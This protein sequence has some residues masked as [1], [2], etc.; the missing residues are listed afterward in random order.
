MIVIAITKLISLKLKLLLILM[1]FQP[2]QM[3][4][5]NT[6]IMYFAQSNFLVNIF[7]LEIYIK[8]LLKYK[9]NYK[10]IITK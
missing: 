7:I 10:I 4:N 9:F 6:M 2:D 5:M 1:R 8:Y 3:R